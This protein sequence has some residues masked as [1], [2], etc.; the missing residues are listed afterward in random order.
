MVFFEDADQVFS[1]TKEWAG[2]WEISLLGGERTVISG[3]K[4]LSSFSSQEVIVRLK[5]GRAV[6]R[7]EELRI[8]KAS[9]SEIFLYGKILSIEF[10]SASVEEVRR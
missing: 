4:G 9:P 10:P 7:G 5:R 3:H 1:A 2:G 6:I 8:A